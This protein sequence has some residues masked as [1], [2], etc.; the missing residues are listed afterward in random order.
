MSLCAISRGN[1]SKIQPPPPQPGWPGTGCTWPPLLTLLLLLGR[2]SPSV[3]VGL[4]LNP[5]RGH[6]TSCAALLQIPLDFRISG[7]AV[8][9][10]ERTMSNPLLRR[11]RVGFCGSEY[12]VM[13]GGRWWFPVGQVSQLGW[14]CVRGGKELLL[15]R[16]L[17]RKPRFREEGRL[18]SVCRLSARVSF[19]DYFGVSI[20]KRC[21]SKFGCQN[22]MDGIKDG[23]LGLDHCTTHIPSPMHVLFQQ[24]SPLPPQ[25]F[26]RH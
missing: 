25:Q 13:L 12:W 20:R 2:C 1:G 24:Q 9:A 15:Y 5:R 11:K 18:N 8:S 17:E 23:Q 3:W 19:G 10:F 7:A 4:M 6:F 22:L 14:V 16:C 21:R 26:F